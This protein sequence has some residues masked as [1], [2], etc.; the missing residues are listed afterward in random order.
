MAPFESRSLWL[1]ARARNALRR[2]AFVAGVVVG[3]LATAGAAALVVP[4]LA[5][6]QPS[7]PPAM[8]P[9]TDTSALLTAMTIADRRGAAAESALQAI[10]V[11]R[12]AVATRGPGALDT[13]R[14]LRRDS[15]V[16]ELDALQSLMRTAE[17]APL[18]PS[19]RSLAAA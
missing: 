7:L 4:R 8:M 3:V 11:R 9:P 13:N 10:R 2:P 18:A 15:I 14:V 19:Y 17:T 12:P 5:A 16:A 1:A 6:R